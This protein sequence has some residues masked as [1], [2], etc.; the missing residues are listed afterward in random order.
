MSNTYFTVFNILFRETTEIITNIIHKCLNF[1]IS[2][3]LA[4]IINAHKIPINENLI[5]YNSLLLI[6]SENYS[7]FI[8]K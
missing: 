1:I 2:T 8:V 6:L 5:K 7:V 3:Q 4:S